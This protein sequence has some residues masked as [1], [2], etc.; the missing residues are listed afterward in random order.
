[1][2]TTTPAVIGR[3]SRSSSRAIFAPS[4]AAARRPGCTHPLDQRR[5]TT[6]SG[7]S[8]AMNSAFSAES[9]GQRPAM[10]GICRCAILARKRSKAATSKI[11]RVT[12]NSAPA[13][14]LYSKRRSSRS[15]SRGGR[16]H[17]HAGQQRRRLANRLP[18]HVEAVIEPAHHVGEADR[19]D[20][21]DRRGIG[22]VADLAHVAGDA[23]Q[24]AHAHRVRAEQVRLDAEQ[25]AVAARIL[26]QRLDAGL[27]ADEGGQRQRADARAAAGRVR[28][29]HQVDACRP[30]SRAAATAS[31]VACPRGGTS[32]TPVTKVP[33]ASFAPSADLSARATGVRASGVATVMAR[34][35]P[36]AAPR[37]TSGA[38]CFTASAIWRM[39]SGVV[40]QQPPTRRT[41][42]AMKRRAY[43]A[44]YSGEHR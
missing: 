32:S 33:A 37:A 38:S 16:V 28:H 12:T 3:S 44:M 35:L 5:G 20:V 42:L 24:V 40:P 4:A 1:M 41:P 8:L 15:R 22:V 39:C 9:N 43:D 23:E 34:W 36:C 31:A 25:V 19:V 10:T 30:A 13:S 14:T 18:R 21:E 7:T 6:T 11:G 29:E 17:H 2:E 27:L 26:E